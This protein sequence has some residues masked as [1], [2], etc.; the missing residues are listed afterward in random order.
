MTIVN[1]ESRHFDVVTRF[2]ITKE[3]FHISK[4]VNHKKYITSKIS[5]LKESTD[6]E[7]HCGYLISLNMT[8]DLA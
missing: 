7:N 4:C 3:Q 1:N 6:L 5:D 2:S 8:C